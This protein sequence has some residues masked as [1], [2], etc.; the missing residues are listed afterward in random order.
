MKLYDL[1]VIGAGPAGEKAAVKAAYFGYKVAIID[2][3][4]SLG[5]AAVNT[6]T[7]PSKTLKETA[8][9][10]SGKYQKEMY[11]L[12]HT[13][14]ETATVDDFL[15][16]KNTIIKSEAH[17]V[18]EN[19]IRHRVDLFTGSARF[20]DPKQ[21]EINTGKEKIIIQGKYTII[22]TGS[23]PYH[24]DDI[25][26]DGKRVHDS[27]SILNIS[28]FPKSLCVI[29]AGVIGCE[30]TTIFSTMGLKV[31]L[32]NS[33]EVILPFLD[34]EIADALIKQ[35]HEDKVEIHFNTKLK[36]ID[37]PPSDTDP[38]KLELENGTKLEVDMF[39][40]AAGRVGNLQGLAT[41]RI[42][43]ESNQRSQISVNQQYQTTVDNIY[44]VGDVIGF[45]S[46]ASTSMDQGRIAVSHIFN[47][48]DIESISKLYPF[49]I[50]T[51][52][53]VSYVGITEEEAIKKRL[54]YCTGRAR[55]ED[56]PRGKIMGATSG[57]LK[58][59]FRRTDLVIIGV[60]I[61]GNIASEIVHYG[62]ALVENKKDLN[63]VVSTIFNYPTLHDLY[64]Y[65]CYDGLGNL[66]GH[67]VK[68]FN[69]PVIS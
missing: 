48:H 40:Y 36:T 57:F 47:T 53:E 34:Q 44:A 65:A 22:A 10:L 29:G 12:D 23:C 33:Y 5:G 16:A 39:L 30:Y 20:L 41:Q 13:L 3:S 9:Y 15:H 31:H 51:V 59:V 66:S 14:A 63:Y 49:G 62:L 54:N 61:I 45:P 1:I 6:G 67:K 27:D 64:K 17:E 11:R 4:S 60:H 21:V 2:K 32:V 46:L 37:V 58:I 68:H 28:R 42:G 8:L 38:I 69:K 24:P 52:P 7:I 25:P 26:F 50:Y 43:I 18:K 55:Y 56:M 35:M 19:V